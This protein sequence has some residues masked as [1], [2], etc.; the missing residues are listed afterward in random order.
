MMTDIPMRARLQRRAAL[1]AHCRRFFAE[2]GVV[3]V[4]TPVLSRSTVTDIHIASFQTRSIAGHPTAYL[5]T[6]PEYAMKRLLAA[7]SGDI[8]QLGKVFRQEAA[9]R[10]HQ[11]EFTLLEWYRL[12]FDAHALI[13][14]V[15]TLLHELLGDCIPLPTEMLPYRD[16]FQRV[17]QIDPFTVDMPTLRAL[18]VQHTGACNI[19]W[20]DRD[21]LLDLAMGLIVGPS[22]GKQRITF[23]T[24][25]P[26]SQAALARLLPG[27]PPRAARFEAYVEGIELCNGFHE[28]T[29][30]REQR[31]RF[32]NDQQRR[33]AM[34]L[35][36]I[37]LDESFLAALETG[38]PECAGVA[39]GF[40]RIVLLASGASSLADVISFTL[41]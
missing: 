7:G 40:D 15:D 24:E 22:L 28:L 31:S 19:D 9:G 17:L 23:I 29:D 10:H 36:S 4:D 27:N 16:A 3:E 1:L 5:Q 33:Q 30:A 20:D 39:V 11:P 6:S 21:T 38:L 26:A 8:Y 18:A 12:G 34:G 25:Y 32:L 14:E 35:E 41:D 13:Q 37:P 2:R